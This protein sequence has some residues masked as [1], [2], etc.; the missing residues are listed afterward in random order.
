VAGGL[1][2]R[3]TVVRK[4]KVLTDNLVGEMK[5]RVD[6]GGTK[7]PHPVEVLRPRWNRRLG[8]KDR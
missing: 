5:E 6:H 1:V 2:D 3:R 4:H 7:N 8:A